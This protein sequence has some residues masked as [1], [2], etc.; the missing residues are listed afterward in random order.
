[1]YVY[2][3]ID[4]FEYLNLSI[5]YRRLKQALPHMHDSPGSDPM[6]SFRA[7][8]QFNAASK[9]PNMCSEFYT[10]W[11]THWGENMANTSSMEVCPC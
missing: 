4:A 5:F 9:S 10:G 3:Y 1:M 6:L 2:E 8:K 7:Q 11:L